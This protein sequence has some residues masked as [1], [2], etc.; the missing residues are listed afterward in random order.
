MSGQPLHKDCNIDALSELGALRLLA[1]H[2]IL[3]RFHLDFKGRKIVFYVVFNMRNVI[4]NIVENTLEYF[5]NSN[6]YGCRGVIFCKLPLPRRSAIR[7]SGN[8]QLQ[9]DQRR[10]VEV[11]RITSSAPSERPRAGSRL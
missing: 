1:R 10:K 2:R 8:V 11:N 5:L 6:N 4:A 9:C 7:A 3:E